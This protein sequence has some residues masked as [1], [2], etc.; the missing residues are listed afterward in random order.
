MKKL[1][2]PL[3]TVLP[4]PAA[5]ALRRAAET[6]DDPKDPLAKIKAIEHA[7]AKIKNEYPFFFKRG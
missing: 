1:P 6:P 2:P 4:R 7:T 3:A 5:L